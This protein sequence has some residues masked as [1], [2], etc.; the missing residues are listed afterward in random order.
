MWKKREEI[1]R[2]EMAGVV[3]MFRNG[4]I[5][6]FKHATVSSANTVDTLTYAE[7]PYESSAL[8]TC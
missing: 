4:A 7:T 5:T 1:K 3:L 8:T 2:S 6:A